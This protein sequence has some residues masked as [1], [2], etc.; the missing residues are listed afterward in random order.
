[1]PPPSLTT[2]QKPKRGRGAPRPSRQPKAVRI[3]P[4]QIK[5]AGLGLF[6]L[7]DVDANEWIAR[8]SGD[9]L[10]REEC[11]E[12]QRSQYRV[13]IHK[14]LF[15]DAADRKHF[16]GRYINDARGSRF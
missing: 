7:E 10:T 6:L 16:E 15:L 12:R 11:D 3:G 9:P 8:Y 1:M 2:R 14:N 5:G 13:Q 4:S